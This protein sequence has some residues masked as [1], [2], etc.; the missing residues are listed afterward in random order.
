MSLALAVQMKGPSD[1]TIRPWLVSAL[2]ASI[3][4]SILIDTSKSVSPI[5]WTARTAWFDGSSVSWLLPPGTLRNRCPFEMEADPPAGVHILHRVPR[6]CL[7][8][9]SRELP[10]PNLKSIQSAGLMAILCRRFAR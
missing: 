2:L 6:T 8:S 10:G 5:A 9:A 3:S 7:R 4:E 1:R